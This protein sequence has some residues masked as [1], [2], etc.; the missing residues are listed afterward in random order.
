MWFR[1]NAMLLLI[2]EGRKKQFHEERAEDPDTN[3]VPSWRRPWHALRKRSI[4]DSKHLAVF[5]R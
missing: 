3:P 4:Q 2:R 5:G 1:S